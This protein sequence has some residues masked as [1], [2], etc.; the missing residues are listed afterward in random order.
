MG[1]ASN[2]ETLVQSSYRKVLKS[3]PE[4]LVKEIGGGIIR[5]SNVRHNEAKD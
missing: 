2:P 5:D 4:E 1:K 3:N